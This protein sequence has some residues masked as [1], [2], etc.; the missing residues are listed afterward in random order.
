MSTWGP[1]VDAGPTTRKPTKESEVMGPIALPGWC[2]FRWGR[3]AMLLPL[4]PSS[5]N[6]GAR[7]FQKGNVGAESS[8]FFTV[9]NSRK[10]LS[11]AIVAYFFVI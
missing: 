10:N 6:I 2:P 1:L 11:F 8:S 3:N 5:R 7:L 4:F 9:F